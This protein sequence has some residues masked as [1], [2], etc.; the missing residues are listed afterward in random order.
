[1]HELSGGFETRL[2]KKTWRGFM[3]PSVRKLRVGSSLGIDATV[4][5]GQYFPEIVK[6]PGADKVSLDDLK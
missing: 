6:V 5:F 3:D 2:D 4:P 1:M